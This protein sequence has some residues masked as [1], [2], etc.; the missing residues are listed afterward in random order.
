MLLVCQ[1]PPKVRGHMFS[2][3]TG[4]ADGPRSGWSTTVAWMVCERTEPVRVLSFL[5]RLLAKF[6]ELTRE[7]GL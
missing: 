7:I 3:K 4:R 5:L 2:T 6:A 1:P